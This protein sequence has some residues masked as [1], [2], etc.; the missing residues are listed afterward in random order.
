MAR[1]QASPSALS[2]NARSFFESPIRFLMAPFGRVVASFLPSASTRT[3]S[4]VTTSGPRRGPMPFS[5][6]ATT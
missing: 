6:I 3:R 4:E 5:S 1:A 2:A